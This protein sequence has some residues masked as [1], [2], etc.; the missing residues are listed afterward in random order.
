MFGNPLENVE[1][2]QAIRERAEAFWKRPENAR[3]RELWFRDRD[4]SGA[5]WGFD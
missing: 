5:Y 2:F 3:Y 1:R 4:P